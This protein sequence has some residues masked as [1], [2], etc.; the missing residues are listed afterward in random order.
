MTS[1]YSNLIT[2]CEDG[3]LRVEVRHHR[4]AYQVRTLRAEQVTSEWNVE[5]ETRAREIFERAV[6]QAKEEKTS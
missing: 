3:A 5:T 1:T 2:W 4:G 6:A